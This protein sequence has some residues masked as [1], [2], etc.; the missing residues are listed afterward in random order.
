MDR[1]RRVY[2]CDAAPLDDV[3]FDCATDIDPP[4][5]IDHRSGRDAFTL[6]ELRTLLTGQT[7]MSRR[8]GVAANVTEKPIRV[9]GSAAA[10]RPVL[11]S[12][13]RTPLMSS[14]LSRKGLRDDWA[15]IMSLRRHRTAIQAR[16]VARFIA[17]NLWEALILTGG[18]LSPMGV[19][20]FQREAQSS[21]DVPF[22]PPLTG[23]PPGHPERIVPLSE[24]ERAFWQSLGDTR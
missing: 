23:L 16:R 15:E 14:R 20:P 10:R 8:P 9:S 12:S 2:L 5:V 18:A 21:T 13:S 19:P 7:V 24:T 17:T 11:P 22:P 4:A 3:A 1:C 6:P